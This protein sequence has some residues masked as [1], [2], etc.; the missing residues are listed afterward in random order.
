M[1][2]WLTYWYRAFTQQQTLPP[3]PTSQKP[4][5]DAA[6]LPAL[7]LPQG[8]IPE[9]KEGQRQILLD[10]KAEVE[11]EIGEAISE[12]TRELAER[13][14]AAIAAVNAEFDQMEQR[15]I[16]LLRQI[17]AL[18]MEKVQRSLDELDR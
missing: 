7:Q 5:Q 2:D 9:R 13:R 8:S 14:R 17:E 10:M 11:R 3:P 6:F 18:K 1:D 4:P 15:E 12:K 16:V